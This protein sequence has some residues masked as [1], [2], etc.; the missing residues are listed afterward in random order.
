MKDTIVCKLLSVEGEKI[1]SP[2]YPGKIGFYIQSNYCKEAWQRWLETQ[3]KL[4]NEHHLNP[5]DQDHR[6][7]LEQEMTNFFEIRTE[8]E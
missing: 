4:I 7:K 5:L 3:T 6:K 2:P 1:Q 8:I